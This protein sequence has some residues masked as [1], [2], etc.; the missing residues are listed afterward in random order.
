MVDNQMQMCYNSL[1]FERVLREQRG[2][3]ERNI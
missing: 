2:F 1:Q 3:D